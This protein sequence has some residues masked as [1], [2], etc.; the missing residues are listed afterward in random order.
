M[1][2]RRRVEGA[3]ASASVC[4][5]V[6]AGKSPRSTCW[7][8]PGIRILRILLFYILHSHSLTHSLTHTHPLSLTLA[9][10]LSTRMLN[11]TFRL[12]LLLYQYTHV[13]TV[14]TDS[15]QPRRLHVPLPPRSH[16]RPR[17]SLLSLPPQ[18]L[19]SLHSHPGNKGLSSS[20]R[21]VTSHCCFIIFFFPHSL[22]LLP[23]PSPGHQPA[24][25]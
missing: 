18:T 10:S 16:P 8:V 9:R 6:C 11:D 15:V 2:S 24:N 7:S 23:M 22:V 5:C 25:L 19:H 4:V 1:A 21:V 13:L 14:R 12:V 3:S 20:N 17:Y